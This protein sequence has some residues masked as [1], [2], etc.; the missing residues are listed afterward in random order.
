MGKKGALI[1]VDEIINSIVHKDEDE[2]LVYELLGN[3]FYWEN[4]KKEIENL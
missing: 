2:I 3:W 4:V 1:A